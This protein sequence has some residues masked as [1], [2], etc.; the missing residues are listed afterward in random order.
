MPG[1]RLFGRDRMIVRF[2]AVVKPKENHMAAGEKDLFRKAYETFCQASGGRHLLPWVELPPIVQD[3]WRVTV[4]TI[5]E[6]VLQ[7]GDSK[8]EETKQ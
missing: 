3:A 6:R 1:E 7:A 2:P 8:E 4:A 5:V